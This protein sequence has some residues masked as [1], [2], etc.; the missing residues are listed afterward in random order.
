M[1]GTPYIA[2][3]LRRELYLLGPEVAA[4]AVPFKARVARE[5]A[6]LLFCI[7][8]VPACCTRSSS[9]STERPPLTPN[10]TVPQAV[11]QL[12]TPQGRRAE[13]PWPV[14]PAPHPSPRPTSHPDVAGTRTGAA[15]CPSPRPSPHRAAAGAWP[16]AA[17]ALGA[18]S[19]EPH[20]G[21]H[22]GAAARVP[23]QRQAAPAGASPVPAWGRAAAV[24]PHAA[25]GTPLHGH[26]RQALRSPVPAWGE[27]GSARALPAWRTG[28]GEG[29]AAG[30]G[31]AARGG[32][33]AP[34]QEPE[35]NC[36]AARAPS[37]LHEAPAAAASAGPG[38]AAGAGEVAHPTA[39]PRSPDSAAS[40][41][42][43][44]ASGRCRDPRLAGRAQPAA[45]FGL[46]LGSGSGP[47]APASGGGMC[48]LPIADGPGVSGQEVS[49]AGGEA[50]T[51]ATLGRPEAQAGPGGTEDLEPNPSCCDDASLRSARG[52]AGDAAGEPDPDPAPGPEPRE[53]GAAHGCANARVSVVKCSLE[54]GGGPVVES[55]KPQGAGGQGCAE[56]GE[57]AG[58]PVACAAAASDGDAAAPGE[59]PEP[60]SG[61]AEEPW[62]APES[63][64]FDDGPFG[65]E[66]QTAE[67]AAAVADACE[68]LPEH[69]PAGS[70]GGAGGSVSRGAD[71]NPGT[72]PTGSGGAS[73]GAEV[74]R[75]RDSW[76]PR[77]AVGE[78]VARGHSDAVLGDSDAVA[79]AKRGRDT[80]ASGDARA[81]SAKRA[82]PGSSGEGLG[83][84]VG[85]GCGS[86]GSSAQGGSG[87]EVGACAHAAAAGRAR[88][89]G[90]GH[91]V[92]PGS[93]SPARQPLRASSRMRVQP[94]AYW[95]NASLKADPLNGAFQ[96]HA[97][98]PDQLAGRGAGNP[99]PRCPKGMPRPAKREP[100]QEEQT[101]S[102]KGAERARAKATGSGAAPRSS[103]GAERAR[104]K[105]TGSGAAVRSSGGTTPLRSGGTALGASR[106]GPEPAV[107][108][109]GSGGG[110][111]AGAGDAGR[112]RAQAGEPA[113][114]SRGQGDAGCNADPARS[115]KP[116][117]GA[118]A[119]SLAR[120]KKRTATAPQAAGDPA[121]GPAAVA[122]AAGAEAGRR[123]SREEGSAAEASK[124]CADPD[125]AAGQSVHG[126]EAA[127]C[128]S[129]R[130][131]RPAG[132]CAP[133]ED[134]DFDPAA[135]SDVA[136]KRKRSRGMGGKG[137]PIAAKPHPAAGKALVRSGHLAC[138]NV[139][140]FFFTTWSRI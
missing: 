139:N 121:P 19:S 124:P 2:E 64:D 73:G 84:S 102:G 97:G 48:R 8:A 110:K 57:L 109:A 68:A 30:P 7:S 101:G 90:S 91:R 93:S 26:A 74:R 118:A 125:H 92:L 11:E 103:G 60:A 117:R 49:S 14:W 36:G 100:K 76:A 55:S 135:D 53:S 87:S 28:S 40:P 18:A 96:V 79:G 116:L 114:G 69:W 120:A 37:G 134:P 35:A 133:A 128:A 41:Q 34:V 106:L 80:A 89:K 78:E 94:L 88:K 3:G 27:S 98:F 52:G 71:S 21:F 137:A 13:L 95:A 72:D 47:Q 58:M 126:Q 129:G 51:G 140:C 82:R 22:Q 38:L 44:L 86:G 33:S 63:Y 62:D 111:R 29:S 108:K 10:N 43:P 39:S 122:A 136:R 54:A 81:P 15:F 5:G 50:A 32:G 65:D 61:A 99:K 138:K 107:H 105:P 75:A 42:S 4:A 12:I 20:G 131:A 66:P 9:Q 6:C 85:W 16:G 119:A 132:A 25:H 23:P 123:R 104:A 115:G 113:G 24:S 127:A 17:P 70:S 56:L 77:E 67:H 83:G 59:A 1:V 130:A 112:A 31:P 45:G 46:W